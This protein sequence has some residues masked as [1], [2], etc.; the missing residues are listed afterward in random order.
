MQIF[1]RINQRIFFIYTGVDDNGSGVA[2]MLEVV[3]QITNINNSGYKSKNT[4]IFVSFDLEEYGGM[5][6]ILIMK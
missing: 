3:R 6:L 2:A 5:L 4:I 1:S